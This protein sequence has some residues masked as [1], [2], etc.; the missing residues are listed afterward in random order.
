MRIPFGRPELA[1]A[2]IA[3]PVA[4]VTS[5]ATAGALTPGYSP[6][7]EPI[8]R[9]ASEGAPYRPLMNTGF[10]IFAVAM[11]VYAVPL[12]AAL[13]GR[14]WLAAVA[15]GVGSAG[16]A[17]TPLGFSDRLDAAHAVAASSTYLALAAL[18]LLASGPL[19]RSGRRR[20]GR[21]SAALGLA[22]GACLW[23]S[24]AAEPVGLFQRA[25]LTLVDVWIVASAIA[26]AR[27]RRAGMGVVAGRVG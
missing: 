5:W 6:L 18:P 19:S 15:A 16:I 2:G 24:I 9:L 14:A 4:F 26:V 20:P 7:T 17:A 13:P 21:A 1:W 25:G 3:G 8:S 23:A 22:A 12:R 10:L 27:R 11:P